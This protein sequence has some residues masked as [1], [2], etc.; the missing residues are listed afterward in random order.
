MT[1]D[2]EKIHPEIV[3]FS[4][5]ILDSYNL[6][7]VNRTSNELSA[8]YKWSIEVINQYIAKGTLPKLPS[9]PTDE[10]SRRQLRLDRQRE[11]FLVQISEKRWQK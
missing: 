1:L 5:E 8:L 10:K 11:L 3:A 2:I 7:E 9:A 6:E 4:K